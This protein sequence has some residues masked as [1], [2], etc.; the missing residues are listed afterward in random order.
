MT[1]NSRLQL[2]DDWDA[3]EPP[4]RHPLMAA[5]DGV[6]AAAVDVGTADVDVAPASLV[7][8]EKLHRRLLGAADIL[9][10]TFA[11][12]VVLTGFH[13]PHQAL[14]TSVG[15]AIILVLFKVGGLYDHDDLRI[16]H[17][18][19]DEL[20][21][22]LQLTGVFALGVAT[23]NVVVPASTLGA[24][25]ISLLWLVSF[26]AVS[27]GRVLARSVAGRASPIERCLVLGPAAQVERIREKLVA[28]HARAI[29]VAWLPLTGSDVEDED[30]AAMPEVLSDIVRDMNVHRIIIAP[31]ESDSSGVFDL[32]RTSKAVGVRVSVLPRL[33]EVVGSA[34]EFDEVD[35][36]TMLGIRRFGLS[37][38]S[39]L[40]KRT[41]DIILGTIGLVIIFPLISILA[42]AVRI[43]SRG[44]IFFRQVRVGRDGE[45]F[46]IFKFRSMVV[47]AD[48]Q[49]E[50]LRA[51]NEAG[52]GLF[53]L[54]NDPRVTKV[55]KL[56]R[57]TSLDELPQLF[58]VLLGEMSLVGPRPLVLDEDIRVVGLDRSRLHL[59]PGMTGPWQILGS[60]VP[61]Q[62]M[63]GIDYLYVANWSLWLDVK[64]IVRT[65]RH[66][67]RR[68][69][70]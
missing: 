60:R 1:A 65:V 57:Q 3:S 70:L 21:T 40:L 16:A 9:T 48:A 11:M 54:T 49:K 12:L 27:A 25:Q 47:G 24:D 69:N 43:E 33:L 32:I 38:S 20:P 62:E 10:A 26:G 45:H 8:R 51:L 53:K 66:V 5:V 7:W 31:T 29:V 67:F 35:G 68:G 59:T 30:W 2:R 64:V 41:F 55:G 52:D 42:L 23:V 58:N 17:S 56:L 22:L 44:P 6:G 63:V 14:L 50:T 37:R 13:Q 19:L 34:V 15:V 46:R 39:R 36:M 61:M 28:S 18:T 4:Q